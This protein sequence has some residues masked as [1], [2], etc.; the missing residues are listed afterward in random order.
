MN[1]WGSCIA[2][3][4]SARYMATAAVRIKDVAY[5]QERLHSGTQGRGIFTQACFLQS[6]QAFVELHVYA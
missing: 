6:C 1:P 2:R 4:V 3:F 5:E